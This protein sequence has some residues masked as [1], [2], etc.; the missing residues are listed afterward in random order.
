M[1]RAYTTRLGYLQRTG[2]FTVDLYEC[3]ADTRTVIR[4]FVCYHTLE[5][6]KTFISVRTAGTGLIYAVALAAPGAQSLAHFELRQ[7]MDPGDVLM[8]ISDDSSPQL[9][10]TGYELSL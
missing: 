1:A 3:P 9:A 4:D 10:V 5:G 8:V 6:R 7:A 2:P